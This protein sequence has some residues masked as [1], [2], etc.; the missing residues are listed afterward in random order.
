MTEAAPTPRPPTIRHNVRSY[1]EKASPDPIALSK[2][3]TAATNITRT[4]PIRSASFPASQPPTAQPSSAEATTKPVSP[5]PIPNVSRMANTAPLIT[6]V[7]N[8]NRKPPRAA[9]AASRTARPVSYCSA[10]GSI[11]VMLLPW[12][13]FGVH[14]A[15]IPT[16]CR[17]RP[18]DARTMCDCGNACDTERVE[19]LATPHRTHQILGEP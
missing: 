7:S 6:A 12:H 10:F 13:Q 9:T 18:P 3:S 19:T 15:V 5:A 14:A 16:M 17:V 1:G 4:R 11:D 8:P 2:N